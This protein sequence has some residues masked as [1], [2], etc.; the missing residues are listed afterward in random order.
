MNY[1]NAIMTTTMAVIASFA[2]A[3]TMGISNATDAEGYKY[4][5]GVTPVLTFEFKDGVEVHEFPIFEM[6]TDFI[7]NNGSPGFT[8]TGIVGNAPHLHKA[9]DTAF[10]HKQSNAHEWNYQYMGIDVDFV[11]DGKSI[12]TLSYHDCEIQ[13]YEVTTLNDDYESYLSS[14][15]GFS[16]VD[17]IEFLCSGLNPYSPSEVKYD[18]DEVHLYET[19]FDYYKDIRTFVEFEFDQGTE[20]IEFPYFELV[21]G[22]EEDVSNIVPAFKV[23]GVIGDY[24][25]L[26]KAVDNARGIKGIATYSNIDFEASVT[27]EKEDG[28]VLRQLDFEDCRATSYEVFTLFD[29]EEGFTGKSGFA[30]VEEIGVEC[31][32]LS[33]E[34]PRFKDIY[35]SGVTWRTSYLSY[36]QPDSEYAS[37]SGLSAIATFTYDHGKETAVFPIFLQGDI[38]GLT[39]TGTTDI[40]VPPTFQLT[41]EISDLPYLYNLADDNLELSFTTGANNFLELFGVD[42]QLVDG[43][44]AY[45]STLRGFEYSDCRITDY[46][47]KTQRDKEE[48]YFKGFA[49]TNTFSFECLGYHPYDPMYDAMFSYEKPT[50]SYSSIDYQNEQLQRATKPLF[51]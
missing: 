47:V 29:K 11:K 49:H 7:E 48:S 38:L 14:K 15:T 35:G 41:G 44:G 26:H 45:A 18:P 27:F 30:P 39:N 36:D 31:I 4:A 37:T 5:D 50:G 10:K 19:G 40:S 17:E 1:K 21:S 42:V 20:K 46:V 34:N 9:L 32:G 16:I 6:N 24:P 23:E 25:L 22:Y 33:G 3:S 2:I 51:G 8:V 28:T 43:E 13:D 12:R